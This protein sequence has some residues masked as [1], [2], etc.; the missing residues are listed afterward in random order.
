MHRS[1]RRTFLT[2]GLRTGA[3]AA[4][5]GIA[6]PLAA[7]AG[8]AAASPPAGRPGGPGGLTVNGVR[9]PVGVDPD[10]VG[11]AW[12]VTDGRRGARQGG[13][14][15]VV[16]TSSGG[17]RP[18]RRP[19]WDSGRVGGA[20][21]A[22]VAYGGPAL[23]ADTGYRWAV[24]TRDASGT[25]GPWSSPGTFV[26]GLR[27]GDWS[28]SWLRPGPA[29]PVP[30]EYAYLRTVVHPSAS[31]VVRATAYVAAAHKYQ[32]WVNGRMAATGPSFAFPDESY[33]QATDCTALV[34][35]GHPTAVGLLHH[36]YGAGNGRPA[37]V[38]GAL[39]QLAVHHADGT[40]EVF[41]TDGTW[42]EQPAEWLPAPPRNTEAHDFVEIVDG[43]RSPLGWAEAGYDD[44][45]WAR[46][47]VLGPAGTPPFTALYA[48]RTWIEEHPVAPS[49]VHTLADG[50]VVVDFGRILAA[51]PA[52]VFRHGASGR[53]VAMHVGYLLDP[54]GQVSTTHGTQGT[55]L[56]FTYVQRDGAQRFVPFTYLG[57]RY[58]QVD[59]PGEP[60]P[61]DRFRALARHTAMPAT[62]PATLHTGDGTL[63]AVWSLCTHS[64]RYTSH[65]QFVD[66]PT[67][68]KGQ[69]ACDS[70]NESQ[71]VMHAFGDRN[72]SWQGLR[73]FARSQARFWPGAQI[74]DI[75]PDGT[76]PSTVPDFT[77]LYAEWL[78]RY[79]QRTGDTATLAAFYP[80]VQGIAGYVQ[81]A[82]DPA[83]GLVTN[84]PGGGTTYAGGAVDWPPQMRYGYDMATVARTVV[85]VLG[86]NVFN[87]LALMATVVG[88]AGGAASYGAQGAALTAAVNAHLTRPDGVYVD[89][90]LPDGSQSTHASQ[91]ANALALAYGLV[92]AD[93]VAA[94][95]ALVASLGI[96]VGPDHGL[97]L[98]RG[99]HAAGLDAHVAR[100]LSD[101]HGP[102]W[103]HI[104]ARGG[105][106]CWESWTPDDLEQDSLS[107]GWGS[108]ALVGMH[109]SLLGATVL[110]VGP[111]TTTTSATGGVGGTPLDAHPGQTL[112][113]IRPPAGGPTA[114]S[115]RLPTV[116]GPV[117]V[118][119]ARHGG[120]HGSGGLSL[121][122]VLPANA[123]A[124]VHLR[125][126]DPAAVTESGHPAASSPGVS[127]AGHGS[128][129]VLLAVGSGSYDFR[130]T[131]T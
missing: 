88:D 75:Y 66:T 96:A 83:T 93:G 35:A 92:P 38:P 9:S 46:A 97:E 108:S 59:A 76:Y 14:R 105:T 10:D 89:G 70:A 19:T 24:R 34:R 121:G 90:L 52:V 79:Y 84:L 50:S 11:F 127:L 41:G 36:W 12:Q 20:R 22:F 29:G 103:A 43:R 129:E 81:S 119:W 3:A 7:G 123:A 114:V 74:N 31:P 56:S 100:I 99:L 1:D 25:E 106:F 40:R 65:E 2:N 78:W 126:A 107:H 4:G 112:L 98:L 104:L 118:R 128:G 116:A 86:A 53:S 94:V 44:R 122:L 42:R 5:A 87:R 110:G 39:L 17:D 26:T 115:G 18:P 63:D 61:K 113:E 48:Q 6:G 67:R 51:R 62:A 47:T 16:W 101:P 64:A 82:V 124:R 57:F 77:E 55:D 21:Q 8:S 45:G 72:Q 73:D 131:A 23:D 27:A 71:A 91:Q 30:E 125:A 130:V 28:A 102:G 37:A 60:L 80:V 15:V 32:L 117:H 111:G 95:G 68:Q 13:Y 109:E 54:D 58:L 85:N 69:F 49:S 120:G 33:Y